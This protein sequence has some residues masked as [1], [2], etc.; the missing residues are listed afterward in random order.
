VPVDE[1]VAGHDREPRIVV[2]QQQARSE[3]EAQH[4][5]ADNGDERKPPPSS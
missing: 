3:I 5:G 4:Q 1:D 2:R